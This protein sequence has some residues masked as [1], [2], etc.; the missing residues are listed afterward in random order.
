MTGLA[1]NKN[2]KCF[3][4]K[5]H[6]VHLI[7]HGFKRKYIKPPTKKGNDIQGESMMQ[8]A[9][10]RCFLTNAVISMLHVY[11]YL[12]SLLLTYLFIMF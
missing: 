8:G 2:D 6:Y 1:R 3:Y 4:R 12:P 5:F 7:C 10:I 9:V 11:M